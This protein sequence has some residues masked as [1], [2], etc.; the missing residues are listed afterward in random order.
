MIPVVEIQTTKTRDEIEKDLE[1]QGFELLYH[2]KDDQIWSN[3]K[4]DT[5]L[6]VSWINGSIWEYKR[7]KKHDL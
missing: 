7:M 6:W 2:W 1:M 4:Q 5:L 3:K